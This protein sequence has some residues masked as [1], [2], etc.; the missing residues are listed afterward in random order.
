MLPLNKE[1][2]FGRVIKLCPELK[3][4]MSSGRDCESQEKVRSPAVRMT[5][6]PYP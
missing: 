6:L 4:N 5:D 3:D 2:H 1:F